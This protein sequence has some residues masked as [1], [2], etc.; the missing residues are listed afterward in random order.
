MWGIRGASHGGGLLLVS[1]TRLRAKKKDM[2][3]PFVVSRE[4]VWWDSQDL[5]DRCGKAQGLLGSSC[6][7]YDIRLQQTFY[8]QSRCFMV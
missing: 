7:G 3:Q 2:E 5:D 4:K 1:R 8:R 6:I